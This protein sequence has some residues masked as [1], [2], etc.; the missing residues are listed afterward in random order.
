[1]TATKITIFKINVTER[2]YDSNTTV[3][4]KCKNHC[5]K[6]KVLFLSVRFSLATSPEITEENDYFR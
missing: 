3:T 4:I 6:I 5:T 1:M 2:S